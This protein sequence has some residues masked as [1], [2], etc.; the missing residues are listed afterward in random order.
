MNRSQPGS[1]SKEASRKPRPEVLSQVQSS[2]SRAGR[3]KIG[4]VQTY[5]GPDPG[6]NLNRTLELIAR[7]A[8]QG[9]QIICTQELFR[10][11]Y[12]CQSEDYEHFRLAEPIPGPSTEALQKVARNNQV[13]LIA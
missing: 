2:A 8:R 13:V 10:S 9:A 7:A 12:F 11:Q 6:D 3:V 4:L 1:K 5:C